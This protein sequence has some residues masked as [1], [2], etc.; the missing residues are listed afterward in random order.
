MLRCFDTA[1]TGMVV[2][3]DRMDVITNNLTNADTTAYKSDYLVSGSFKDMMIQRMDGSGSSNTIGALGL[4]SSVS[5]VRTSFEQGNLM[6]TGRTCDFALSGQGFFV[7]TT[8]NGT[9]YTRDGRFSVSSDG[10]LVNSDGDYVQ[11][12]HGRIYIGTD[13]FS[14]DEQGNI[15]VADTPVDK[16]VI[17]QFANLNALTGKNL[18]QSMQAPTIDTTTMVKQG[19]LEESNVDVSTVVSDMML[20]SNIYQSNQRMLRMIDG[21]LDKAVN[22]VGK[23]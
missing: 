12:Q 15:D 22:E 4:G 10:Y 1:V 6:E 20:S 16:F 18:Y 3:R 23:V 13:N 17:V 2:Q 5:S 9:R 19:S 7:V 11:G 8:P 14:V 21:T